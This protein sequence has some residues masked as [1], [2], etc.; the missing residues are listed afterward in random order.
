[1]K[2]SG[3][4]IPMYTIFVVICHAEKEDQITKHRSR[5]SNV[6]DGATPNNH[7]QGRTGSCKQRAGGL[8]HLSDINPELMTIRACGPRV[9][10][11]S[12]V[13]YGCGAYKRCVTALR[14]QYVQLTWAEQGQPWQLCLSLTRFYF[15][16]AQ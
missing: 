6:R 11:A 10:N 4:K 5:R 2:K 15:N 16:S 13:P 12:M 9:N 14:I 3:Y 1:M 7:S 8:T